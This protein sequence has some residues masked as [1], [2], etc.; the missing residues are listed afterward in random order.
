MNNATLDAL[1]AELGLPPESVHGCTAV[2]GG[3]SHRAYR[4]SAANRQFFVK[5][6]GP[7]HYGSLVAEAAGLG[8]IAAARKVPVPAVVSL[9]G[10]ESEGWLV[11]EWLDLAPLPSEASATLGRQ[12]AELHAVA[13]ERYG[14]PADNW[15]G[16]APQW[17]QW[18]P[19]WVEFWRTQRL[20]PLVAR[21]EA[22][23]PNTARQRLVSAAVDASIACLAHH[24]PL[25]SLLHGDLWGG[26]A[27][28]DARRERPVVFDPAPYYGDRETDLAM[29]ALFGGFDAAFFS[30]YESRAPLPSGHEQRRTLYQFYHALNHVNLFGD[31]YNGMLDRLAR[32]IVGNATSV[33]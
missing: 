22:A 17:N 4:L 18:C 15:L 9:G 24:D 26:N 19:S 23:G 27:A 29:A 33:T 12:L 8:A 6:S 28:Y 31:G 14:W 25:P 32:A 3:D 11:L 13:S 1:L 10:I 5:A 7:K 2:G 30:A 21:F 16:K 20:A